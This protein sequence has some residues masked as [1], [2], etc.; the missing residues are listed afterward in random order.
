MTILFY[1]RH[2]ELKTPLEL[3]QLIFAGSKLSAKF[4]ATYS[5]TRVLFTL[6]APRN[7]MQTEPIMLLC[8]EALLYCPNAGQKV[9]SSN[10]TVTNINL[11]GQ[12]EKSIWMEELPM[13]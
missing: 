3:T 11:Q 9:V 13:I 12:G 5:C 8:P 7:H 10:L 4:C 2:L 1:K 6:T